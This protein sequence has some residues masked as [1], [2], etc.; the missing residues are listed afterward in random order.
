[1]DLVFV[2]AIYGYTFTLY[3]EKKDTPG[4][5]ETKLPGYDPAEKESRAPPPL[6]RLATQTVT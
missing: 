2:Y 5:P 4:T 3:L 6:S 1:M